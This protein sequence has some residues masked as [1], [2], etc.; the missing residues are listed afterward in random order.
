MSP[1]IAISGLNLAGQ[2]VARANSTDASTGKHVFLT[3]TPSNALTSI[4]C[5]AY[6]ALSAACA[7]AYI[8]PVAYLALALVLSFNLWRHGG[9]YMLAMVIGCY[10]TSHLCSI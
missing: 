7:Q 6:P 8:F 1:T 5:S 4:C 3:Y 10:G 2:L 9:R